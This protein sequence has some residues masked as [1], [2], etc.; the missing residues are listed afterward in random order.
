MGFFSS[1]RE[2][3]YSVEF[4]K[5]VIR[6]PLTSGLG[7]LLSW[8]FLIVLLFSVFLAVRV[9][10]E[11]NGFM[12]WI[13]DTLPPIQLTPQ[14]A[15]M[16]Q[17]SPFEMK[18]P[19]YGH[20]ATIDLDKKE[21]TDAQMGQAMIFMT[22]SKVYVK[23]SRQ[24]ATRVYDLVSPKD[25]AGNPKGNLVIDGNFFRG[26]EKTIKPVAFSVMALLLFIGFFVW[27]LLAAFFYSLFGMM[28]NL[29][30]KEKLS[31]ETVLNVS[32]YAMTATTLIQLIL[33]TL[34][35]TSLKIPFGFLGSF[36]FTVTY[37][38]L[39]IK[40]T[41]ENPEPGVPSFDM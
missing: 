21:I 40:F 32:C 31:Y 24:N 30:R 22:S 33:M 37:L 36:V 15:R 27:K 3:L 14:G 11:V 35:E 13:E 7:Y 38:Y 19:K 39:G 4:Y 34:T 41:E 23:E 10:P 25:E 20:I 5:E 1:V 8:A 6:R 9:Y 2:S 12:D 16:T 18:H 17:K 26:L 28:I 29:F